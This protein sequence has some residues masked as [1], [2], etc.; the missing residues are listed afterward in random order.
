ML[1]R[2]LSQLLILMLILVSTNVFSEETEKSD[3]VVSGSELDLSDKEKSDVDGW[4]MNFFKFKCPTMHAREHVDPLQIS[5]LNVE[6]D[7]INKPLPGL[8]EFIGDVRLDQTDL[9]MAAEVAKMDEDLGLF[10]ARG[11]IRASNDRLRLTSDSLQLDV[12]NEG[13]TVEGVKFQLKQSALRGEADFMRVFTDENV[14]IRGTSL[15][16][17][18]PGE[19]GWSF[20]ADEIVIDTEEG[21]GDAYHMLLRVYD[22]PI[23]YLPRLSF[24]VDDRRKTGFLY[25]SIGSSSRNGFELEAPWYWN[26]SHD[27][28]ATFDFKY[29]SKRGLMLGTEYRQVTEHSENVLYLE[30]LPDDKKGLPGKEDR[31]FYQVKSFY[32]RGDHWRGMI[33]VNTVSDDDYFYDFGGNFESGN[34]NYLDRTANLVYSEDN[35][36]VS[37]VVSDDQLLSTNSTAYKRMPQVKYQ[38]W[39]P[40]IDTEDPKPW[41]FNMSMEATAFRHETSLE[42]N[43]LLVVPEISYPYRWN[44]GYIEPKFKWHYSHY[45]QTGPLASQNQT[46]DREVTIFSIDSGMSF[47]RPITINN[48]DHIQT[49]EPRFYYLKV[50]YKDQ[51]EIG[52]YD[53]T[54][55]ERMQHRLFTDNR[56]SGS[57]RIG[58]ADQLSVGFTSRFIEADG[59]REWLSLTVGQAKYFGDRKLNF[60]FDPET[61]TYTDLGPDKSSVS[62]LVTQIDYSPNENWRLTGDIEYNDSDGRTQQGVFSVQYLSPELVLNLRHRTNRYQG[63]DNIEQ[64]EVSIARKVSDNLSLIGRWKQD[65]QKDR[66]IDSFIGLEYEDCCWAVRLVYRRYLNIRLDSSGF[67]VP[68]TGEYNDGI[69]VEFVLKG[70]TNLGRRLDVEKD[71]Y[72]YRDRLNPEIN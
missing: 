37:A 69:F 67:A 31:Y 1:N 45:D 47:E 10:N 54:L 3:A 65:F 20:E 33:D 39:Q 32:H 25:P 4:N 53:T 16:T 15:T 18:P 2:Q 24:P 44:W 8:V 71:I 66:T 58:D 64:A 49:L 61:R 34:R 72:G 12:N 59:H 13:M 60:D 70:L 14:V 5:G 26:I 29:F 68:G 42:A 28:D 41:V 62:P 36:A 38:V 9:Q 63:S 22:I 55:V 6:A 56:Y 11:N 35:W 17:C 7:D 40:F 51:T 46:H 57:D 21:W 48:Q 30:Y 23:F 27:K 50:P 43:R 19:N 52:L